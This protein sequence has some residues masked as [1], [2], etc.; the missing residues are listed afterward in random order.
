M[1]SQLHV[2][3]G[4]VPERA[5]LAGDPVLLRTVPLARRERRRADRAARR[6]A[7]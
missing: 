1:N 5:P 2:A 7:R 3:Y 6:N 4:F